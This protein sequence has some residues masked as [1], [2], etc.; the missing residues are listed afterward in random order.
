MGNNMINCISIGFFLLILLI[1]LVY[2]MKSCDTSCCN[3]EQYSISQQDKEFLGK[4]VYQNV[5]L[6]NYNYLVNYPDG[7]YSWGEWSWGSYKN[8]CKGDCDYAVFDK[9]PDKDIQ[10]SNQSPSIQVNRNINNI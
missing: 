6:I 1:A 2:R 3:S 9:S 7:P 8:N 4:E 5:P 10:M